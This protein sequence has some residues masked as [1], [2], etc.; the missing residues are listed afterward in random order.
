MSVLLLNASYEPLRVIS[1]RRALGLVLAGKA[2]LLEA[3][4]GVFR[5]ATRAC[6][7]PLVVRLRHMVH[8]PFGA[9]VPLTRRT[10][11]ARD[12]GNCQVSGCDRRGTTIDHVVPRSR[13]GK[14]AWNNVALMCP[15]H[16]RVKS[17]R[18]M[19]DLGWSLKSAPRAPS[20]HYLV[21]VAAA[22]TPKQA[23]LRYLDIPEMARISETGAPGWATAA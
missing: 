4:D 15:T 19:A 20:G 12:R 11:A 1:T 6:P 23:W 14:H 10:L 5:S 13:G 8:I 3:G 16:N 9:R 17:D 18:L 22:S 7:V 21:L 2:E